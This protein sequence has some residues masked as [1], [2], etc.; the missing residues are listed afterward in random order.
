MY[1]TASHGKTISRFVAA[2]QTIERGVLK[3]LVRCGWSTLR[4]PVNRDILALSLTP[5]MSLKNNRF[6]D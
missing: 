4:T 1:S 3:T 6:K 5:T 2:E